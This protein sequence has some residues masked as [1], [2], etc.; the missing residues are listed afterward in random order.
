[1]SPEFHTERLYLRPFVENDSAYLLDLDSDPE[2]MRFITRGKVSSQRDIELTTERI[3][4]VQSENPGYGSWMCFSR[5][6]PAE[7]IGWYI[8]RP[9]PAKDVE[10]GYRLKKKFWGKG[11]ASEGS[12]R[13][14]NY[15]FHE[16][17]LKKVFAITE[18]DHVVSQKILMKLGLKFIDTRPYEHLMLGKISVNYYEC[19]ADEYAQAHIKKPPHI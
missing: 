6:N 14:L 3:L 10:V 17:K 18:P 1:M 5:E 9:N 13:L 7:F 19:T 8:L 4:K 11:L 12:R 16:K 15:G 2:V